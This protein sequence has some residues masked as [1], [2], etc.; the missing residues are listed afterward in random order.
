MFRHQ[1]ECEQTVGDARGEQLVEDGFDRL[2]RHILVDDRPVCDGGAP[3]DLKAETVEGAGAYGRAGLRLNAGGHLVSGFASEREH[4]NL[5][6]LRLAG[7]QQ[8][9][10]IP[11]DGGGFAGSGTGQNQGV[12]C[13]AHDGADLFVAQLV[14]FDVANRAS[15][16]RDGGGVQERLRF[17]SSGVA[18]F[19]GSVMAADKIE[20]RQWRI[21]A[22]RLPC[23]GLGLPAGWLA[24]LCGALWL[25]LGGVLG[26]LA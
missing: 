14:L 19:G 20:R 12:V 26:A 4:E 3:A 7:V 15:G 6:G 22:M 2:I 13:R 9:C 24:G 5:I 1:L 18:S 23:H 8:P 17:K 11:H 21:A 25:R 10:D 16:V